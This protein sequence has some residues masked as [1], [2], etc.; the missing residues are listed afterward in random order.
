MLVG[1]IVTVVGLAISS[2][3]GEAR[4]L[5]PAAELAGLRGS[6]TAKDSV[7]GS[8]DD[9]TNGNGCAG[10]A[11]Q[12]TCNSCSKTFYTSLSNVKGSYKTGAGAAQDCGTNYQGSCKTTVTPT[13]NTTSCDAPTAGAAGK[14][15]AC[16]AASAIPD[17]QPP[18]I[19][20]ITPPN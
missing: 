12:A 2:T 20:P 8:C 1:L 9:N 6:S 19:A 14:G 10:K 11:A 4:T 3:V 16:N 17:A 7:G 13:G 18:V 5:I 15:A